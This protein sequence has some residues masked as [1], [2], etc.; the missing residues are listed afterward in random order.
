MN[1]RKRTYSDV[2]IINDINLYS[3]EDGEKWK[4]KEISLPEGLEVSAHLNSFNG[5]R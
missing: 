4:E 2:N 3:S 1:L 5:Y